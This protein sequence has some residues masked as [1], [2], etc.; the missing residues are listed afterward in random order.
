MMFLRNYLKITWNKFYA[1]HRF[2][3]FSNSTVSPAYSSH[4]NTAKWILL[5]IACI[6]RMYFC[7]LVSNI[8]CWDINHSCYVCGFFVEYSAVSIKLLLSS[9]MNIHLVAERVQEATPATWDSMYDLWPCQTGICCRF[10]VTCHAYGQG[11]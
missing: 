7:T 11:S 10:T 6:Y 5:E 3:T 1:F 8:L 2:F 9:I 4:K